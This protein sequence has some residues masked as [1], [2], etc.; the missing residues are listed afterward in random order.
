MVV[1]ADDIGGLHLALE[2]AGVV[3]DA[4]EDA[5]VVGAGD[6]AELPARRLLEEVVHGLHGLRALVHDRGDP[7]LAPADR[8]AQTHAPDFDL[9]FV[10]DLLQ[11]GEGVVAELGELDVVGHVEVNRLDPQSPQRLLKGLAHELGREILPAL[12][13]RA[14]LARVVVPVVAEL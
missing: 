3:V 7:F 9:A 6:V 11:L 13:V 5:G 1:L 4:G 14:F 10:L 12:A 8:G 2:D